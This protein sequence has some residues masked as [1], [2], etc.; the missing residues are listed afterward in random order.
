[1]GWS[2]PDLGLH[3]IVPKDLDSS[4]HF[5]FLLGTRQASKFAAVLDPNNARELGNE[6]VLITVKPDGPPASLPPP[7]FFPE[8]RTRGSDAQLFILVVRYHRE[9]RFDLPLQQDF[10]N[11]EPHLPIHCGTDVIEAD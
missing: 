3:T 10:F 4:L 11:P 7:D 2:D 5:L 6:S 9:K 8:G 1:M